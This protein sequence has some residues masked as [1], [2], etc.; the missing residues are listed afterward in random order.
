MTGITSSGLGSGLDVQGIVSGLVSAEGKPKATLLNSKEAKLQA[1]LSALGSLKGAL[2]SFQSSAAALK[3]ASSFQSRKT[4]ASHTDLFTASASGSAAVGSF[5]MR[6]D[7]MAQPAKMRSADF[8]SDT[9]VMGAGSLA[10][11][12]GATSFNVT[13][14]AATTLA[15]VRDAINSASDNP[16][17][18]AT[19][20]NGDSGSRL[21]LTSDK[22]GAANTIGVVATD[23]DGGDGN[24][25]T[26]LATASL[27]S[28]Q[29]ATDAIIQVDGQTATKNSNSFSDVISGVTITLKKADPLTTGSLSIAADKD[30]VTA[31]INSFV[32]AYNSLANTMSALSNYDATTKQASQLFGDVTLLG[33]KGQLRQAISSSVAGL[34]GFGTLA[35]LGIKTNKAGALE[36]DSTKLNKAMD[37]NFDSVV[38]LFSATDGVAKRLDTVLTSYVSTTGSV[39]SRVNSINKQ[40]D[41]IGEQRTKLNTRLESLQKRYTKQFNAMDALVGGL[42]ATGSYLTQQ[43]ANLP[44]F[45]DKSNS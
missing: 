21:I 35:E 18:K 44:G 40:I 4:T 45:V 36:I 39:A 15:G 10:I 19:I 37:T 24:D 12:L 6:V 27:V 16:G 33:A 22:V 3:D 42:Q 7:Q 23:T 2:A 26:R 25:L 38:K 41:D 5:S 8:V 34:T 20:V 13:V 29:P 28:V 31:K 9:A 14:G 43:L 17:I 30:A 11:S 32:S 1:K